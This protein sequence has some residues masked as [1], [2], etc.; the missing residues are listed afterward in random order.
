MTPFDRDLALTAG[1]EVEL[2]I[3]WQGEAYPIHLSEQDVADVV[4]AYLRPLRLD[5]EIAEAVW[6][7]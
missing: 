5:R 6:P 7:E 4:R 1:A 2:Q 3:D